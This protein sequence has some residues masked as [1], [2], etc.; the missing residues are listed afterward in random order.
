MIKCTA[1]CNAILC[2]VPYS[3]E[4]PL[5]PPTELVNSI[6]RSLLCDIYYVDHL[7]FN[8]KINLDLR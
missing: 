3:D 4:R 7:Y 6:I 2:S 1:R 5:P 8:N